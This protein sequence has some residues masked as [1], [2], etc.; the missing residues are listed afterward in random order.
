MQNPDT[1]LL[2]QV[3]RVD[4]DTYDKAVEKLVSL[5]RRV[6]QKSRKAYH[7]N[8]LDSDGKPVPID[9]AVYKVGE[10]VELKNYRYAVAGIEK[11]K[12]ILKPLGPAARKK[13]RF[14][15]VKTPKRKKKRR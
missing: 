9:W 10:E 14:N 12:L 11:D 13:A 15:K 8:I 2:E 5:Q 1:N 3:R 7:D 4:A 6:H